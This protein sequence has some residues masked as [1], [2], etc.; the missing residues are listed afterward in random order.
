MDGVGLVRISR[1]VSLVGAS[2]IVVLGGCG[3]YIR[4]MQEA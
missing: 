4:Q 2:V 1:L 3:T